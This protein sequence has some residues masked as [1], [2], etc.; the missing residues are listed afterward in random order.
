MF[1]KQD[2]YEWKV[3]YICLISKLYMI[4]NQTVVY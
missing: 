1:V 2:I 4:D 3:S